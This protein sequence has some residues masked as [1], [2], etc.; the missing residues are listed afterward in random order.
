MSTDSLQDTLLLNELFS[1]PSLGEN[2]TWVG[3][4]FLPANLT[5]KPPQNEKKRK[6]KREVGVDDWRDLLDKGELGNQTV[7][8][9]KSVLR[10]HSL[11][12][13]GNKSNLL[14]RIK[15]HATDTSHSLPSSFFDKATPDALFDPLPILSRTNSVPRVS[16]SDFSFETT[17]YMTV[18]CFD[19]GRGSNSFDSRLRLGR[20][21]LWF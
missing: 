20:S 5:S 7:V 12:L 11:P 16:T 2:D 10:R 9:L 13:K 19:F 14:S 8:Y 1:T 6:R 17:N 18:S 21:E 15:D 4:V 3:A